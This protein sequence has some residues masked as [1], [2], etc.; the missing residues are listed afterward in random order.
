[1]IR[2]TVPEAANLLGVTRDAINKRVQRDQILGIRT[3]RGV[4]ACM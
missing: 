3:R 2:L 4:Y 1:M